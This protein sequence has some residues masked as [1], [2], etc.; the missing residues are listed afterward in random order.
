MEVDDLVEGGRFILY[1]LPY[2]VTQVFEDEYELHTLA[3]NTVRL[4][5]EVAQKLIDEGDLSPGE[6]T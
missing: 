4:T 5:R 1:G 2:E 6:P 3:G